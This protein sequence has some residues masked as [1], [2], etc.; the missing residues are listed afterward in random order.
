M[1]RFTDEELIF[2]DLVIHKW[3]RQVNKGESLHC[4]YWD[5]THDDTGDG[6]TYY[7]E[8]YPEEMG[9]VYCLEC[10]AYFMAQATN[11]LFEYITKSIKVDR[12]MLAGYLNGMCEDRTHGPEQPRRHCAYCMTELMFE[13]LKGKAPWETD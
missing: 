10:S 6:E 7:F 5:C 8:E 11:K 9:H 2:D 4:D 12:Q 3:K 13:A 1:D